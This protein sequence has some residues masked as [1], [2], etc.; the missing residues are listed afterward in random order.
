MIVVNLPFLIW[1]LSK[2][3]DGY[4]YKYKANIDD[5]V[6]KINKKFPYLINNYPLLKTIL[7]NKTISS[8]NG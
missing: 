1:I 8:L 4:R 2:L 5:L 3:L 7:K 6:N